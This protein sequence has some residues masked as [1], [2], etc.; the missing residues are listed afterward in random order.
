MSTNVKSKI[1]NLTTAASIGAAITLAL[2]C[3]SQAAT[4]TRPCEEPVHVVASVQAAPGHAEELRE[5]LAESAERSR[6]EPGNIRYELLQ[7]SA[8]PSTLVAVEEWASQDAL[9]A[10]LASAP[11]QEFLKTVVEKGLIQGQPTLKTYKSVR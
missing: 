9:N 2:A 10:H 3:A 7:D 6:G 4:A 8:D 11:V 5:M 1:Q